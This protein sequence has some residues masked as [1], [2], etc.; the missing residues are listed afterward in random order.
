MNL[1]DTSE[2]ATLKRIFDEIQTYL[3]TD[4]KLHVKAE[5]RISDHCMNLALSDPEEPKF[6]SDPKIPHDHD[7]KCPMCEKMDYIFR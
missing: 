7:R 1:L 2:A 6:A 3:R 5:S 4:Y